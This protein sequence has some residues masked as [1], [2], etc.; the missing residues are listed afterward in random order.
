MLA[1]QKKNNADCTIAVLDDPLEEASLFGIL[2][3]E[4]DMKIYEFEEKPRNPKRTIA[5]IAQNN[6]KRINNPSINAMIE[7][8]LI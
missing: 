7:Y 6:K 8:V 1:S 4:D 5:S 3:T 2:N